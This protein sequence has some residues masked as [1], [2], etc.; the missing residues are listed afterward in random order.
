MHI[1]VTT[2]PISLNE[3]DHPESRPCVY[4]GDGDDGLEIYFENETN[5]D[6]FLAWQYEQDMDDLIVLTGNDS[7]D[8]IAEG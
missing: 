2:D 8:Y 6:K 1:R 4:E 7:E 3:V 5:R